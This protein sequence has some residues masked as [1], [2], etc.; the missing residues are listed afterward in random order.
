[1]RRLIW[2]EFISDRD[3]KNEQ[4]TRWAYRDQAGDRTELII[5]LL[6]RLRDETSIAHIALVRLDDFQNA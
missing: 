1:M 3:D 2:L 4:G 5:D 6:E